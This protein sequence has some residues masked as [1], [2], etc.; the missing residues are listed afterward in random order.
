MNLGGLG[1]K[2]VF[3]FDLDGTVY[4]GEQPVEGVPE[5]VE[6]LRE[7]GVSVVFVSNNSSAWR[8]SYVERL[9]S[10]GVPASEDDI[11][12]STESVLSVLAEQ[13][14]TETYVVGTG[15]MRAAF[16]RRGIDPVAASPSHVVVG[17]DTELT[18]AKVRQAALHL[19][20]GARFL[21]AHPDRACPT[22]EGDIPDCGAIAA[23]LETATGR[24]PDRVL[25]KPDPAMLDPV[26][27]QTGADPGEVVVVGDR[28][29][30][31]IGLAEAAGVDSVL[32]LSGDTSREDLQ[33]ARA[34]DGG[35]GD[36]TPDPDLVLDRAS[37]ILE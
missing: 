5:T 12:L 15:A 22:P 9:S 32:V 26:Y 4:V 33:M 6:Q 10:V 35:T 30:T 18:Y 25:G 16:D 14:V 31:D 13:G 24:E 19:Q 29:S 21:L 1:P 17:F 36:G 8:D 23:L 11:V 34:T 7:R 28:L 2:R 37:D 20:D 3:V 27:E